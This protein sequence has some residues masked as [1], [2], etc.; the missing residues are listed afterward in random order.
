MAKKNQKEIDRTEENL[1]NIEQAIGRTERFVENN[2][3]NI[4]YGILGL[5]AIVLLIMGYNKYIRIP[6]EQ[7]AYATIWHAE[8]HFNNNEFSLA[9]EGNE[10][11]MGFL[12]IIDEYGS[13]NS[14][15]LA[16]YYAGI[17]YFNIAHND[18]AK[19][20]ADENYEL[21]IE[22]LSKYSSN[23]LNVM[24]MAIGAIGDCYM[25]LGDNEKAVSKYLKAANLN[26]NEFI[27]PLF[28]HKAALTYSMI[29]KHEKALE[30]FKRIETEYHESFEANEI[31]KYIARE[32]AFLN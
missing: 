28:L 29:N 25:E 13:T 20:I 32:K 4:T 19:E 5:F 21:A 12:E 3:N 9:L 11:F 24:P 7:E 2:K 16:K 27:T 23:D 14:G 22:Y 26:D 30:L 6:S 18:T 15:E 10:D 8:K 1:A 31:K 17:C